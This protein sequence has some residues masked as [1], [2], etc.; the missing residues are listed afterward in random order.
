MPVGA[1]KDVEAQLEIQKL[2]R[3]VLDMENRLYNVFREGRQNLRYEDL[4]GQPTLTAG[5]GLSG[6]GKLDQD[7]QIDLE[8]TAV[9]AGS[10]TATDLTVDAQGRITAASNGAGGFDANNVPDLQSTVQSNSAWEFTSRAAD[11][12]GQPPSFEYHQSASASGQHTEGKNSIGVVIGDLDG[13]VGFRGVQD[14]ATLQRLVPDD[15]LVSTSAPLTGGGDLS[16]DRTI[17]INVSG[18]SEVRNPDPNKVVLH[19]E[20]NGTNWEKTQLVNLPGGQ[21][22]ALTWMGF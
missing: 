16:T 14:G 2:K 18:T 19:S 7:R 4:S 9:S 3:K 10:Y 6:G 22:L 21:S 1:V 8:D 12:I 17:S 11:G 5:T 15:T 13:T 20:A